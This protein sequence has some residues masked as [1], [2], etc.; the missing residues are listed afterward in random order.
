MDPG[1]TIIKTPRIGIT[2]PDTGGGAA[3][4]FTSLS[5]RLA[6]GK[7]IRIR[8][9]RPSRGNN[10]HG[11]ILGGGADIDPRAY[12]EDH[13]ITE[14]LNQ[15]LRDT[16]KSFFYRIYYFI[17][18]FYYP[19]VFLLRKLLSRKS[20]KGDKARDELEFQLLKKAVENKLPIMG[21]C[22]GAQLIN[23]F[24]EGTL[25][26]NINQF[27]FE[28]PNKHSIFPVKTIYIK[29]DSKLHKLL[30]EKE[31]KVNALHNQAVK[32]KGKQLDIVAYE[33]NSVV[34]G[35]EAIKDQL[36]FGVQWHPEY[37]LL[38]KNQRNLFKAVVQYAKADKK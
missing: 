26:Q 14:Y 19:V 11:L 32:E 3:W 7:P 30:G 24:F 21:I 37:L 2:G 28:E 5:V 27:Y 15:T 16:R 34:Q 4:L 33:P 20:G 13:F 36:I 18:W 9:M 6:G 35:I 38:H 17:R 1:K 8:P 29:P 25:F 31:L 23:V 22:R 10:I 12:T